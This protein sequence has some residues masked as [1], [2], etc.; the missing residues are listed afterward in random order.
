MQNKNQ[1]KGIVFTELLL[2]L[3]ITLKLCKVI[4]WSW[5]WVLSPVWIPLSIAIVLI[6]ISSV[7]LKA[8][9]KKD[10]PFEDTPTKSRWQIRMEEMQAKQKQ[11]N[12]K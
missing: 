10:T 3:F 12:E 1:S 4:N 8:I 9:G 11:R 5:L 2:L 6:G 7:I